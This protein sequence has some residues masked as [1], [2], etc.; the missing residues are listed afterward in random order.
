GLSLSSTRQRS[1]RPVIS[2]SIPSTASSRTP[3][4]TTHQIAV[5]VRVFMSGSPGGKKAPVSW[6]VSGPVSG[7]GRLRG[8]EAP[9]DNVVVDVLPRVHPGMVNTFRLVG[10]D[11]DQLTGPDDLAVGQAHQGGRVFVVHMEHRVLVVL[12]G[13]VV[14]LQAGGEDDVALL[15][16]PLV[17]PFALDGAVPGGLDAVAQLLVETGVGLGVELGPLGGDEKLGRFGEV[18]H[19]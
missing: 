14:D 10:A 16:D 3:A 9:L 11:L 18:A 6:G 2:Y 7:D 1:H 17:H 12:P 19:L 15:P 13:Q 8:V 4:H 5:Q